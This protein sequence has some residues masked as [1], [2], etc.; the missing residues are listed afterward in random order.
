MASPD[1]MEMAEM[2][3]SFRTN[4][5]AED[6]RQKELLQRRT[7]P[8]TNPYRLAQNV[9]VA[10]RHRR[11]RQDSRHLRQDARRI[12]GEYV[13]PDHL[14][15]KYSKEWTWGDEDENTISAS[16]CIPANS[17]IDTS[18]IINDIISNVK[19]EHLMNRGMCQVREWNVVCP[20]C[21]NIIRVTMRDN[22][23]VHGKC[24]RNGC[25]NWKQ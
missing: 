8:K 12:A 3:S 24:E 22:G 16:Q 23:H 4:A 19:K 11:R 14:R 18:V 5:D 25:L 21:Q 20:I 15:D 1:A 2:K 13:P 17:K 9:P 10:L 7:G 6:K